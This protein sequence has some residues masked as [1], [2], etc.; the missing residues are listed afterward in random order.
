MHSL[1]T[2]G[3][4]LLGNNLVRLLL[5]RGDRVRVLAR[6][7]SDPRPLAG[8]DVEVAPGDVCDSQSVERACQGVD[9]VF[10]AAGHVHIGWTGQHRH[11]AVNVGGTRNVAEVARR[12]G[13]RMIHVSSTDTIGLGPGAPPYDETNPPGGNPDVPYIVT[14][15]AAEE[16]V[17]KAVVEGLNG[18][19]VNPGYLLGPWDWKPSSGR[20]LLQVA[21]G[22]ALLAPVG[23]T[24]FCDARD[25]AA[26][27]IAAAEVGRVG[28]RYI[29]GGT[30]IRYRDAWRLMAQITGGRSPLIPAGPIA[31][32]LGGIGGGLWQRLT[33]HEPDINSAAIELASLR[34]EYSS[35]KAIRELGYGI[36]PLEETVRDAWGWFQ[37]QGYVRR[38]ASGAG[39]STAPRQ[40]TPPGERPA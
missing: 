20:M 6:V 21:S 18:V 1:V 33:G 2:G 28:E 30:A 4:G 19:I 7:T 10:H 24:T 13:L 16:A 11:T 34:K 9:R 26:G 35:A 36:R 27:A 38:R 31:R 3:T 37:D 25:V 29:L 12:L 14:K 15:I 23:S 40:A 22:K 8:L 39:D 5:A 17:L 32:V